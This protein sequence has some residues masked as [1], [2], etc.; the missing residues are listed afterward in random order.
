M[1]KKW[2]QHLHIEP[3]S[4]WLNDPNGLCFFKDR[5]H[6][7][8][9]Y[10]PDSADGSS[11][12][13]WGHYTSTD[14]INWEFHDIALKPDNSDDRNGVYSGSAVVHND[15]MHIFYTGNV[16]HEGDFDYITAGR[17]ANV[18][19]VTSDDGFNMN[20]KHTVLKNEDYPSF[21]SCHVRDPKVW[22]ENNVWNMV[23]GARTLDDKGCVLLYQSDDLENWSYKTVISTEKP[24]GYMWEC[25]DYYEI[26]GKKI[27]S[28]SPQGLDHYEIK[29]Q[30]VYQS[31]WFDI[32]EN[33]MENKLG[34]F[35]EWDMGFDFYAPQSFETPDN[36][37]IMIGWMGLPDIDYINPTTEGGYQHC[38]T[39]PR[40]I[41]YSENGQLLQYPIEEIKSLRTT[42]MEFKSNQLYRVTLPLD[43]EANISESFSFTI[44]NGLTF[45]Y[46]DII[47]LCTLKFTDENLGGGRK[48]RMSQLK[49]CKSIR[50]IADR[51]G[52]EI[53]MNHGECVFS[54]RF[55]PDNE[56]IEFETDNFNGL[57][58]N[59][60]KSEVQ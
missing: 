37:R 8:F 11:M 49:E 34:K 18:I 36:R 20:E 29:Y 54:S 19:H 17:G 52:I 1:N 14:M 24:F 58:W 12:K 15:T 10:S 59:M 50:I 44:D 25:P 7:F 21:C 53:F 30:N 47:K 57:L 46:D 56:T 40:E 33:L 5:Y 2:R 39:I 27:L 48:R 13:C 42:S 26:D 16:K 51:S 41:K 28:I 43:I 45:C 3:P 22:Y 55:Y 32:K 31:G 35:H 60:K 38:L 6:V 23:L 9:Q 4:G